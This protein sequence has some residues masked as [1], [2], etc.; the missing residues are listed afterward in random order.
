MEN[1]DMIVDDTMDLDASFVLADVDNRFWLAFSS[2]AT[3]AEGE[4]VGKLTSAA[5][6]DT[7]GGSK[8]SLFD[9]FDESDTASPIFAELTI[10]SGLTFDFTGFVLG[11]I[12]VELELATVCNLL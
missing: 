1:D 2:D 6:L 10:I 3:S 12:H 4:A 9:V 11:T 7:Q 5:V 8:S